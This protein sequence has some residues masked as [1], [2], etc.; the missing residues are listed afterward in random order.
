MH[1]E[2]REDPLVDMGYEIR[3]IN[4]KAIK[5]AVYVFLAFGVGCAV[6]GYIIFILM[7]PGLRRQ[8]QP[9]AMSMD[10]TI[11]EFPNPLLQ[12]NLTVRTDMF[13]LRQEELQMLSG[14]PTRLEN[15]NYRIP[16]E[17]AINILSE[18]GRG[19]QGVRAWADDNLISTSPPPVGQTVGGVVPLPE[20]T[21]TP[22]QQP[23]QPLETERPEPTGLQPENGN[24]QQNG[25]SQQ[26]RNGNDEPN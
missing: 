12:D 17:S 4:V 13:L 20:R 24:G 8:Q 22:Q 10:R 3:D 21:R 1:T 5:T 26:D 6:L 2:K 19:R 16:V 14:A 9:S 7:N 15:G 11:P 18:Q 23:A 25:A